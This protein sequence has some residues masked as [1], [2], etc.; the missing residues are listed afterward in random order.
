MFYLRAIVCCRNLIRM[1]LRPCFQAVGFFTLFLLQGVS[2]FAQQSVQVGGLRFLNEFSIEHNALFQST[3]IGGLSGID[4]DAENDV[5]Y[6]LCDDRSG[7]ND[8]RFYTAKISLT[9]SSIDT[10]QFLT[11]KKL[12]QKEGTPF[13]SSKMNVS[14]TTDPEALRYNPTTKEL[15]WASEGER[16]ISPKEKVL[17]NPSIL[18]CTIEGLYLHEFSMPKNL[19]MQRE[20]VGPRQNGTLEGLTFENDYS[21]LLTALEEPLY[22]DG[23]RA[24][25]AE[26]QS[27]VRFYR[28]DVKKKCNLAQYAYKLES[29]AF[30]PQPASGFK[31]NGISDILS[32]GEDKT[33]VIERSYSTGRSSCTIK[34]FLADLSKAKDIK[35]VKSLL[36]QQ[37]VR[38][39]S[40][41]LL[42]NMDTLNRY[43]DN[44]EG[45]TLGPDLPNGNKS[46]IF[47]TDNN[48][49][50]TQ[51]TQFLLF[52]ILP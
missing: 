41:K 21:T 25:V 37:P 6:L 47:V 46:L 7:I 13:P 1:F 34:V 8:A 39:I 36:K 29:I 27:W 31:V 33:L 28:F 24:D 20:E 17:T 4:Y 18:L 14:L 40:K 42:F 49:L 22:Q 45:V 9:S 23:V 15:V 19:R 50:A 10:I 52:E 26:T 2:A 16:I 12:L 5:Y 35:S 30:V 44:V 3:V 43:I 38:P 48:F 11:V 51:K 32:I